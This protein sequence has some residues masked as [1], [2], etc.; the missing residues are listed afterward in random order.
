MYSFHKQKWNQFPFL[1]T[2]NDYHCWVTGKTFFSA[3]SLALY[4]SHAFVLFSS[5]VV[6]LF[7]M[8]D[9]FDLLIISLFPSHLPFHI[10]II[11]PCNIL[12]PLTSQLTTQNVFHPRATWSSFQ[13]QYWLSP[14]TR[15]LMHFIFLDGCRCHIGEPKIAQLANP[16]RCFLFGRVAM[17]SI[18]CPLQEKKLLCEVEQRPILVAK[19]S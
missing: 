17:E 18:F 15:W 12:I 9:C 10:R 4:I 8:S 13:V 16:G 14:E 2:E 11:K 6:I 3:L 5:L 7:F 19:P 1:S